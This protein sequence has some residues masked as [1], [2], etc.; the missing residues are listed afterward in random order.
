[1]RLGAGMDRI[2]WYGRGP[3]ESYSDRKESARIGV[4]PLWTLV[5]IGVLAHLCGAPRGPKEWAKFAKGL[6]QAQRR[7]L[8]VRPQDDRQYPAPSQTTF[9][10]L[11]QHLDA[12]ELEKVFLQTQAQLRGPAPAGDLIVLDGSVLT[13]PAERSRMD[14]SIQGWK[15]LVKD[16]PE[17]GAARMRR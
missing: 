9:W 13:R 11:L 3:H 12:D 14:K 15:K 16:D 6:S 2:A 8:G 7:A 4:Y 5:A 17:G 1:M 10:R